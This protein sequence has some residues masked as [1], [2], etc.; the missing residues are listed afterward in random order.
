MVQL[1]ICFIMMAAYCITLFWAVVA[2]RDAK[3]AMEVFTIC[4][5]F[6]AVTF[7]KFLYLKLW[8]SDF[9]K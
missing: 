6:V 3:T 2:F 1:I 9:K 4:S 7:I 8:K 5:V